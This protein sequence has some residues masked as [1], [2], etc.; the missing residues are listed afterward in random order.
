[1]SNI[2]DVHLRL[3][4]WFSERLRGLRF[5]EETLAYVVGV[6]RTLGHPCDGDDLSKRSIVLEY[7]DA[8]ARG[9]FIGFQRIGDWVLWVNVVMPEAVVND[10]S[11]V[12]TF[13]RLSYRACNR[14]LRGK[15]HVYEELADEL[16][17][18]VVKVRQKLVA[19]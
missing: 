3:D 4:E 2:V 17:V 6:L 15:W 10:K 9:E 1:M 11:V 18:L 13:G 12:E 5:S 8:S 19:V 14:I 16:P 7:I